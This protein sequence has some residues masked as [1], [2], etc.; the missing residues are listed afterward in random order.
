MRRASIGSDLPIPRRPPRPIRA[1]SATRYRQLRGSDRLRAQVL[2]VRGENGV[3]VG[4]GVG[5]DAEPLPAPSDAGSPSPESASPSWSPQSR[6]PGTDPG[7]NGYGGRDHA[8]SSSGWRP[9]C[10]AVVGPV[11]APPPQSARKARR[12]PARPA[13]ARPIAPIASRNRSVTRPWR[14]V[15]PGTCSTN[16][17]QGPRNQAH[18]PTHLAQ[19]AELGLTSA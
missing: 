17:R 9:W 5:V 6:P 18:P 16:A 13:R 1:A 12:A 15:S 11:Q 3:G 2:A 14:R 10:A 7:G 19:L 4:P 8:F